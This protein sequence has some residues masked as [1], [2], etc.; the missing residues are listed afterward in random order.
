MAQARAAEAVQAQFDTL[1]QQ[2]WAAALGMWTFLGT[3]VLF[4]GAPLLVYL[5]ARF[6]HAHAFAAASARLETPLGVAN[7]AVLLTSSLAMA[8]ADAAAERGAAR[9]ARGWLLATAALG[10]VFIAVKGYE[11][12]TEYVEGLLPF[13][14]HAALERGEQLFFDVY[15]FLTGLHAV[16]LTIGIVAVGAAVW[17]LGTARA[18]PRRA[19]QVRGTAL[20]WHF[21]DIVWIFL[22]PLL[23]LVK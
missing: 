17:A 9:R 23:Y 10:L 14:P 18:A 13:A 7:T 12:R 6:T 8:Y 1:G 4:F 19:A 15:L 20:Y 2:R 21:V 11:W 22:L 5:V 3:E 16:H